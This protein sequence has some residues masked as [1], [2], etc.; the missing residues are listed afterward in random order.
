MVINT[1]LGQRF[2]N[3]FLFSLKKIN[4]KDKENDLGILLTLP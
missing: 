2:L 4:E 3:R 1:I